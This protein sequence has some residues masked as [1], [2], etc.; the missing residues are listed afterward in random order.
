V[1][2]AVGNGA[3]HAL[4]LANAPAQ[5]AGLTNQ[6][7]SVGQTFTFSLNV[8]NGDAYGYQW[9]LNGTNILNATNAT[10][11]DASA[12]LADAGTYTG[13]VTGFLGDSSSQS[14]NLAVRSIPTVS[15]WPTVSAITY[16]QTLASS[17]LDG[18][19]ASV[20]GAFAWTT[21][22]TVFNAGTAAPG[23]TFTPA[24]TVTYAPV[25]GTASVL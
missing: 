7:I 6:V 21:P 3:N 24:D 19:T 16:G 13:L 10:Y 1:T 14:A 11:T 15:A 20:A 23:V 25:S 18:G 12:S 22:G 5:A 8:T 17:T 9:Q 2:L 4:V